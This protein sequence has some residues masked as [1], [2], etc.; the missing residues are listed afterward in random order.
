[1]LAAL[2]LIAAA[3]LSL[4][5]LVGYPLLLSRWR[6]FGPPIRKDLDYRT[7]VTVLLAVYNGEAFLARKLDNLLGLDYPTELLD[8]VV[9]SDGSTDATDSIVQAYSDR[10]VRLVRVPHAGKAAALNAAMQHAT[11][12]ILLFVDVRQMFDLQALRHL[13]ANFADSTVGGVT[14][15][16]CFVHS[17]RV[18]EAADIDVYW[19][20]EIWARQRHSLID[21]IFNTTGCIYA[22]RRSLAEPIPP[23]T[24]VDDA[25]IPLRAFFRGYRVVIDTEALAFDYGV[26]KGGEFC[27]KMRT[28]GGVWQTWVRMP[29]LFTSANRMR[30]HFLPHKF[31]RVA[32]PWLILAGIGAAFAL[33]DTPVRTFL[34]V[35]ALV[36]VALAALD[37]LLPKKF[38]LR[39]I[40][41][42]ARSFVVL[43]AASLLAVLVFV[44][45]PERLW[46]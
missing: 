16:L 31:G 38:F 9:V 43:N 1:M 10:K 6:R 13:V 46:K 28:L 7:T 26:I 8:I 33:P 23:D 15:E 39:H 42:P 3:V 14:G 25:I 4:Y 24:L 22:L 27:R 44:V 45:P 5:I 40:S 30:M 11:G 17:D 21:S 35:I 19:R 41:S 29:Q 36:V 37:P 2:C 32:L 12:E 34:L 20:Y 18:G